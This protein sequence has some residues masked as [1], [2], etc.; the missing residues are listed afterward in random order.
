MSQVRRG[1]ENHG[2]AVHTVLVRAA[3]LRAQRDRVAV[4]GAVAAQARAPRQV[5]R[6]RRQQGG[7]RRPGREHHRR[8]RGHRGRV[9]GQHHDARLQGTARVGTGTAGEPDGRGVLRDAGLHDPRHLYVPLVR[10]KRR[11][12]ATAGLLTAPARV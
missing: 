12:S 9:A 5:R 2:R 10:L 11:R 3:V 4:P 7:G 6:V 8:H 1:G